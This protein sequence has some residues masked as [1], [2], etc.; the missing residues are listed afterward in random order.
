MEVMGIDIGGSG[1]KA[2]PVDTENGTLL[3]SRLRVKTPAQA[4][5]EPVAEAVAELIQKFNWQGP[6][7]AGFPA[8]V[9]RG[10]VLTAANI[11]KKW[12][13]V[14]A[15]TLFAEATGCPVCVVNDADA[16]GIAEMT[17]GAGRSRNG[18]VM[19]ITIGTGL[20]VALFTDGHLLPNAELGHIEMRGQEAE[21]YASDAARKRDKLSWKQWAKR[22]DTYLLRMEHLFWPDLIILGGGISADH[23][24]FMPYL[25]VGTEVVPA[26]MLNEAGIVGAAMAAQSLL[27][28][29]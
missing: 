10:E 23:E 22:F 17:F 24:R 18:V 6:I 7:G 3:A 9:R 14:N 15:A 29:S 2:A 1:I 8:A 4:K 11:S 25:T 5:P 28:G 20:G 16:A 27:V 19:M 21:W 12:L 26:Q 13:G